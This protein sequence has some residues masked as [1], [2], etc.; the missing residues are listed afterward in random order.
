[1]LRALLGLLRV[2]WAPFA[3]SWMVL[4][5]LWA[6]VYPYLRRLARMVLDHK[7]AAAI[8]IVGL[9][10]IASL[11]YVPPPSAPDPAAPLPPRP[12]Y[13]IGAML[14]LTGP[15]SDYGLA[16]LRGYRIAADA[17]N[18]SGI[19]I[20]GL[21]TNLTLIVYDDESDPRRASEL[22]ARLTADPTIGVLLAPYSSAVALPAARTA[23]RYGKPIVVPVASSAGF[24]GNLPGS[25]LLLQTP[26]RMHLQPAVAMLL[27]HA[28]AAAIE[29]ANLKIALAWLPDRHSAAV[30]AGASS[31]LARAGVPPP[32][33]IDLDAAD[34]AF[35]EA[36]ATVSEADAILVA[37]YGQGANRLVRALRARDIRPPL[38]AMTHCVPGRVSSAA[39][40]VSSGALCMHH[41][42]PEAAHAGVPPLAG[43][44]F[45][46]AYQQRYG[47][48]APHQ[49]AAA[50]AAIL[51]IAD[52]LHRSERSEDTSLAEALAQT[53]LPTFYGRIAFDR[54]GTNRSKPMLMSQ[55]QLGRHVPIWPEQAAAGSYE[56]VEPK[57]ARR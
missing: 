22:A 4:R 8:T 44:S 55:L 53:D 16:M 5:A 47:Q 33:L 41:W 36:F 30:A 37:G 57:P 19:Q 17:V 48:Q 1:M 49:A 20:G 21:A 3:F 31:L 51:V 27:E 52:A 2:L 43:S 32:L 26:A 46:T 25:I 14:P 11:L 56:Q 6:T 15:N 23:A 42:Q 12:T 18:G 24:A 34:D 28:K 10:A 45:A 9:L 7:I 54:A 38:L 29:P 39:P 35:D 13:A 50:G 40:R